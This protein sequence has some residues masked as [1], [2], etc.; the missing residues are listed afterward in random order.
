MMKPITKA[1]CVQ[2]TDVDIVPFAQKIKIFYQALVTFLS[3]AHFGFAA[4]RPGAGP[5]YRPH[6]LFTWCASPR[7]SSI[8]CGIL[9]H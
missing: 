8:A 2:L 4:S 9:L 7:S 6:H 5:Q 3:S 1:C